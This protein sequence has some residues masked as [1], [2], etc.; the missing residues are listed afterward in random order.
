MKTNETRTL[1]LMRC[2]DEDDQTLFAADLYRGRSVE[3]SV[4]FDRTAMLQW[5]T[6][7]DAQ[8]SFAAARAMDELLVYPDLPL[9]SI[10]VNSPVA[11]LQV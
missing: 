3:D 1:V 6:P 5:L 9:R 10:P 7:I 11:S 4:Y 8:A 2:N